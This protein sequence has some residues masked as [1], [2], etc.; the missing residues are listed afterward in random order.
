MSVPEEFGIRKGFGRVN[1]AG[2]SLISKGRLS[3]N[4]HYGRRL[5]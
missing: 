2:K 1:H 3:V 4:S 5:G